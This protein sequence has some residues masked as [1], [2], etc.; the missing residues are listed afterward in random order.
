[1]LEK[2]TADVQMVL[3]DGHPICSAME[4]EKFV[5]QNGR[6]LVPLPHVDTVIRFA[7]FGDVF[8]HNAEEFLSHRTHDGL[9]SRRCKMSFFCELYRRMF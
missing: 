6:L 8:N 2:T 4:I 7:H 9:L 1:M 3:A 5:V